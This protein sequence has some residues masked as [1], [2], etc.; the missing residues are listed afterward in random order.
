MEI[1]DIEYYAAGNSILV[2][3]SNLNCITVYSLTGALPG[4]YNSAWSFATGVDILGIA[5]DSGVIYVPTDDGI[6]R[7][8]FSDGSYIDTV[9]NFGDGNGKVTKPGLMEVSGSSWFVGYNDGVKHF[10]P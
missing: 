5:A 9:A 10:G 1:S 6:R 7:Y 3:D 8:N 2:A 4:N